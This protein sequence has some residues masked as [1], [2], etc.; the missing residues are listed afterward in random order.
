MKASLA[1]AIGAVAL[2]LFAAIG[3]FLASGISSGGLPMSLWVAYGVGAFL[4]IIVG[5]SLF[6]LTFYSARA[7]YD[8]IDRPEDGPDG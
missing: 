1:L 5:S 6:A 8:E 7:G 4:T 2:L 3:A